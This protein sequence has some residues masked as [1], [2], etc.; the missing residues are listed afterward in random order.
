MTYFLL[1]QAVMWDVIWLIEYKFLDFV[2]TY[3]DICPFSF[4]I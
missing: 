1:I 3:M 4:T 2:Y